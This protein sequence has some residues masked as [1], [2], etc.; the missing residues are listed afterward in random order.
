MYL[1]KIENAIEVSYNELDADGNLINKEHAAL[2]HFI[3]FD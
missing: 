2:R 1:R 3:N